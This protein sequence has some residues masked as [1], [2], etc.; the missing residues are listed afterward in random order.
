MLYLVKDGI[1]DV[2]C[3]AINNNQLFNTNF[4]LITY[5]F[6]SNEGY[7]DKK[8]ENYWKLYMRIG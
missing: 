6:K 1:K 8:D 4:Y 2:G 7:V 3:I 5:N